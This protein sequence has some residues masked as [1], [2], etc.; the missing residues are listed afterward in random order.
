MSQPAAPVAYDRLS[1]VCGMVLRNGD[2]PTG[3]DI[4]AVCFRSGKSGP[5]RRSRHGINCDLHSAH[6]ASRTAA[7]QDHTLTTIMGVQ[8]SCHC[9]FPPGGGGSCEAH[10]LSICR[11][12]GSTCLHECRNSPKRITTQD[13]L[14]SWSYSQVTN[15]PVYGPLTPIQQSVLHSRRYVDPIKGESITFE[16]PELGSEGENSGQM[17]TMS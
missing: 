13:E 17:M 15:E 5:L 1:G 16:L 2:R 7:F 11:T 14:D 10:Q 12:R 3:R 9:D 6:A 8:N 4:G